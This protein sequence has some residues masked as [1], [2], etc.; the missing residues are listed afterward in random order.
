MALF[1]YFFVFLIF[2]PILGLVIWAMVRWRKAKD[3][4]DEAA[5][6]LAREARL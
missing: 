5:E 6:D 1:L 4:R 3:A 2:T